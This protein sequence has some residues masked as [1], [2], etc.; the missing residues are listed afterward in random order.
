MKNLITWIGLL[1]ALLA[2]GCSGLDDD[3]AQCTVSDVGTADA[4]GVSACCIALDDDE[5]DDEDDEDQ[6]VD[7]ADVPSN[8]KQAAL[9]AVP[10]LVL[11][12]ATA[13]MDDGVVLY[14]D[15]EGEVG[16]T[17]YELEV[18]PDGRVTEIE[19]EDDDEEEEDDDEED[20]D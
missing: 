11:E 17:D 7:L 15:L 18:R 5:D 13:A 1:I 9:A 2:T 6:L 8:V 16:D 3:E 12:E 4:C 20:D 14:Y 10:G 19:S